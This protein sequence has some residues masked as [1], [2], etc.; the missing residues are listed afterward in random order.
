MIHRVTTTG[1]EPAGLPE[2]FEA[3]T[4]A[5]AEAVALEAA[6]NYLR[7]IGLDAIRAHEHQL[8]TRTDGG[9]R[10]IDG[11]RV[12]GPTPDKKSAIVSFAVD[13]VHAHDVSQQLDTLGIAVRAGHHC[14]M[15]LHHALGVTATTRASYYLYNTV[16]EADRLVDAVS[17][18]QKKFAPSGRRRRR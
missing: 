16:E 4:P 14:T 2:K 15:P 12:I 3:G 1:F 9:L 7:E 6:V 11:V 10:E 18:V 8:C 17:Q 13:G 5:I